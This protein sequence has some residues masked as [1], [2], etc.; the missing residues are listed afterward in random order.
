VTLAAAAFGQ[1]R[2]MV[3]ASLRSAVTDPARLLA[4]AGIDPT[5]R[6]EALTPDAYLRLAAAE[7]GGPDSC[8]EN[9]VPHAR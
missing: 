9:E 8:R 5:A 1:R 7:T 2:K 3:R 6:A 4:A